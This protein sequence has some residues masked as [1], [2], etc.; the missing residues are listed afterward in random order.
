MCRCGC[1]IRL[2]GLCVCC[3]G[4]GENECGVECNEMEK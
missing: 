1:E 2:W 3:T 4:K